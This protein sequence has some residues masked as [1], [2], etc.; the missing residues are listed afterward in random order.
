MS[1]PSEPGS[2]TDIWLFDDAPI[3]GGAE[4]FALRLAR[5]VA[6]QGTG[7]LRVV[8]PGGSELARQCAAEGIEQLDA[9]FPPLGP[10]GI[11]RW[12]QAVLAIRALLRRAGPS[13]IVIGNT[14]RAQAYLSA[15]APLVRP[16][17]RI[18]QIIH[19]QE[20]LGRWSGRFAFRRVG[21]LVAVGEKLAALCRRQLPD[22]NVWEANLFLLPDELPDRVPQGRSGDAAVVGVLARLI[23]E[24][25]L[26]ELV[27]ELAAASSWSR[28]AI[29]GEPQDHAYTARVEER[30]AALGLGDRISLLGHVHDVG[31]FLRSI[32]VLVVPSTGTEGQGMAIIEALAH[33]VGCAVRRAAWSPADFEGFPVLPYDGAAELE[34]RLGELPDTPIPRQELRRRFGPEQ[35]FHAILAAA[36]GRDS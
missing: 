6:V 30:I 8:C 27:D 18:V 32:D 4:V 13:G 2:D 35:A 17:A 21:S 3:M 34:A 23:P 5:Y 24:K 22:V 7:R 14:A 19:E 29:A 26:L 15:A 10:T 12:P 11:P 16:R 31:A 20:T 28:A 33:G 9:G 1:T 25:G 36:E